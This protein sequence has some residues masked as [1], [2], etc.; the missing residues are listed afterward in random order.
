MSGEK[1]SLAFYL[2]AFFQMNPCKYLPICLPPAPTTFLLSPELTCLDLASIR[3]E[4]G[5]EALK[6]FDLSQICVCPHFRSLVRF[7]TR[8][9][10]SADLL[11]MLSFLCRTLHPLTH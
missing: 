9:R 4:R 8:Q 10:S 7:V 1:N 5:E 2:H 6:K 3:E 11:I